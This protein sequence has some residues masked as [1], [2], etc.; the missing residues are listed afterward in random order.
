LVIAADQDIIMPCNQTHPFCVKY[1]MHICIHCTVL[2][3][4][5]V[6]YKT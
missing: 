6:N 3:C 2:T 1:P 5:T 4:L